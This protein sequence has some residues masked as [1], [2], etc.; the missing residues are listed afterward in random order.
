MACTTWGVSRITEAACT[1]KV[2]KASAGTTA[3]RMSE[4]TARMVGLRGWRVGAPVRRPCLHLTP[5]EGPLQG[6][7]AKKFLRKCCDDDQTGRTHAKPWRWSLK[8][9]TRTLPA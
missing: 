2:A 6:A 4:S 5:R 3:A 9:R 7:A 1:A 8:R